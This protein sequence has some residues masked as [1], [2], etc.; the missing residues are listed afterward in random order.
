MMTD[1]MVPL[2]TN[3]KPGRLTGQSSWFQQLSKGE[4]GLVGSATNPLTIQATFF[5]F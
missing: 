1:Y 4:S 3:F 2:A 5:A